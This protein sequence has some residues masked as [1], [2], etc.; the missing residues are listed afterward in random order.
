[1][2]PSVGDDGVDAHG[3]YADPEPR[4]CLCVLRGRGL[5]RAAADVRRGQQSDRQREYTRCGASHV[6]AGMGGLG[7]ICAFQAR[8]CC[9]ICSKA[10]AFLLRKSVFSPGSTSRSNRCSLPDSFRY[11]HLPTRAESARWCARTASGRRRARTPVQTGS[12]STPSSGSGRIRSRSR[13]REHRRGPVH[14]NRRLFGHPPGPDD[15]RPADDRRH[16]RTAFDQIHLPARERPVERVPLAAVVARE[17]HERLAIEIRPL[18]RLEHAADA[19]VHALHHRRRRSSASR[20]SSS[21]RGRDPRGRCWRPRG[22]PTARAA[23]CSED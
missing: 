23:R 11:F 2:W 17:D 1:M 16:P 5:E 15:A 4:W 21:V 9:L 13:C 7:R 12:R 19:R 20:P 6:F 8:Y 22:L 3:V 10:A 18:E 14:R